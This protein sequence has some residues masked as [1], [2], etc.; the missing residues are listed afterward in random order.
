MSRVVYI[1]YIIHDDINTNQERDDNDKEGIDEELSE[2]DE[3][4]KS[5]IVYDEGTGMIVDKYPKPTEPKVS[6]CNSFIYL[7]RKETHQIREKS[8][9]YL[10]HLFF[11]CALILLHASALIYTMQFTFI[12]IK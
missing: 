11:F 9:H 5:D 1:E 3:L 7:S 10:F 8:K 4:D 2:N 6:Q 12:I